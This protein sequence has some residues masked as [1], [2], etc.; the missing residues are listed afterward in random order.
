MKVIV[1]T[2]FCANIFNSFLCEAQY[3]TPGV[4]I[5]ES[6]IAVIKDDSLDDAGL[7]RCI[8]FKSYTD[9]RAESNINKGYVVLRNNGYSLNVF[10]DRLV[11]IIL[12]KDLHPIDL[13]D[14]DDL[15]QYLSLR[16]RV[17][18]LT[19][20]NR[21]IESEL[22][23]MLSI[24][25]TYIDKYK[26]NNILVAGKWLS[27]EEIQISKDKQ[28]EE[29]KISSIDKQ[30]RE[31]IGDLKSYEMAAN[32]RN[33]I[34][35]FKNL[36]VR[37]NE[38]KALRDSIVKDL[39]ASEGFAERDLQQRIEE[40]KKQKIAYDKEK[41]AQEEN[42]KL[43]AIIIKKEM[44]LREKKEADYKKEKEELARLKTLGL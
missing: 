7:I 17:Y 41:K 18:G 2:F 24:M 30:I 29:D 37:F 40:Q 6:G 21:V 26:S 39:L 19:K 28:A 44:E 31:M 8:V 27:N 9:R 13:K 15:K 36:Q 32:I 11:D 12:N 25:D 5:T 4:N 14:D 3:L 16:S 34:E 20:I 10:S 43:Q 38:N 42:E 1:F 23:G 22:T 33:K 35:Q